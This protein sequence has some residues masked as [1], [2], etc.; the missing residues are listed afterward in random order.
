MKSVAIVLLACIVG[1]VDVC[2]GKTAKKSSNDIVNGYN[3]GF[4]YEVRVDRETIKGKAIHWYSDG[5]AVTVTPHRVN[6][7]YLTNT[8]DAAVLTVKEQKA[9]QKQ[10]KKDG[11]NIDK[12]IKELEKLKKKSSEALQPLYASAIKLFEGAKEDNQ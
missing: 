7:V 2:F 11:K 5:H 12:A 1:V 4:P 3:K 6:C 10:G 8:V 9:A